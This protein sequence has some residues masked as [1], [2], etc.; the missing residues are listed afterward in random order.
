MSVQE[1]RRSEFTEQRES[2]ELRHHYRACWGATPGERLRFAV[3]GDVATC[4]YVKRGSSHDAG[5]WGTSDACVVCE[6][7]THQGRRR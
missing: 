4:G 6:V 3:P 2:D 1:K 7:L 5:E